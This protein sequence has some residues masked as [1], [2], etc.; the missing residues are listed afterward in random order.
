MERPESQL[1]ICLLQF[2]I[3][4]EKPERNRMQVQK[5]LADV[6]AGTDLV[7]LP[8][9]FTTG[10]SMQTRELAETMQGETLVWMKELAARNQFVVTG[11][12]IIREGGSCHNRLLFVRPSG[13]VDFYDK[14]HLFSIGKEHEKFAPGTVRKIFTLKGFRILPQICY[15]LRFPVFARN[16]GDYD[17]YLN[18]ANWPASRREVWQC[19][20]KARAIE[21]QAYVI[22]VNRVGKDGVGIC[23]SGDSVMIDA[24]GKILGEAVNSSQI[25]Y[26]ELSLNELEAFRNKFPVLPDADDFSLDG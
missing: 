2:D 19:L 25:L 12:V 8:E 5:M 4:W 22:G 20:L 13:E 7:V 9:M 23:Y 1:K 26:F 14:R 3:A 24:R 11:S 21:N 15:D 6:P 17:I 16:R 18:C 10:F